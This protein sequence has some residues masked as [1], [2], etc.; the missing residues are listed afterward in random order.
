MTDASTVIRSKREEALS[1]TI[2]FCREV[3]NYKDSHTEWVDDDGKMHAEVSEGD[4]YGISHHTPHQEMADVLDSNDKLRKHIEA[5]RGSYK[6]TEVIGWAVKE[7]LKNPNTRVLY[8]METFKE[9]KKKIGAIQQ[10]FETNENIEALWGDLR[11]K[12]WGKDN[13]TIAGRTKVLS[14]PTFMA[15]GVD[16][17]I[18]GAHFDIIILDD[19]VQWANVRTAEGIQK[20]RDFFNMCI[21]LLDP[22]GKLVVVG[23][24]YH[25]A[26]LYGSIIREMADEFE[27]L[28]LDC[29]FEVIKDKDGNEE[30]K[31]ESIF[32]HLTK[33]VLSKFLK[34]MGSR[35]FASQYLNKCI[36]SSMQLFHRRQFKYIEW[37]EGMTR[38]KYYI[39]T[40]TATGASDDGC[41]SVAMLVGIDGI[42]N[43]YLIDGEVG[44]FAPYTFVEKLFGLHSRWDEKINISKVVMEQI[45]LNHVFLSMIE[46]E[47][48]EKQVRLTIEPTSRGISDGSKTQRIQGLQGRFE[49][50]RFYV[51]DTFPRYFNDGKETR[52]LF[53]PFGYVDEDGGRLPSGELVEQFIRFPVG[54][55]K[56][57]PDA[58]ADLE[59][60]G[61]DGRS[62]CQGMGKK[63][64]ERDSGVVPLLRNLGRKSPQ[65]VGNRWQRISG[66]IDQKGSSDR[67]ERWGRR[68]V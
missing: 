28:I 15:G 4:E 34:V 29:G 8:A 65:R 39:F 18:T 40:D 43:S 64:R 62:I 5:P 47:M 10:I 63:A 33:D 9:A 50:G 42:G 13:F 22:G 19:I 24:R 55:F 59:Y 35:D 1:D 53:S 45:G 6:S 57:I 14:D 56:D 2:D 23:T 12:N 60:R 51:C 16:V 48:I 58:L 20:V 26:D 3:L 31:G 30:L 37:D 68:I 49:Q 46:R 41:Y 38:F 52:E 17:N 7:V 25:D 61:K 54:T 66:R 11:T 67:W 21:P 44:R 36:S 27:I 32:P